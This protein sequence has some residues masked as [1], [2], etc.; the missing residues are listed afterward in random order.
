M[1]PQ[2]NRETVRG[3]L[4][5]AGIRYVFLG[6]ELG[7][8]SENKDCYR[9]GQAQYDLLAQTDLFKEGIQ[10]VKNGAAQ[11]RIALM[12]AEKE[13]LN[14]H[15]AILVSR[16]LRK[17]DISVQH[18]LGDGQLEDHE[19]ALKRLVDILSIPRSDMFR[20]DEAVID[21]AYDRQGHQIAYRLKTLEE[22]APDETLRANAPGGRE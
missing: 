20:P 7:A 17:E 18:I 5:T 15:R 9:N 6:K 13:P 22:A 12:C 10:R 11:Y 1:N 16:K 19:H 2:F 8:R 14:C 21:D 3:S 4:E